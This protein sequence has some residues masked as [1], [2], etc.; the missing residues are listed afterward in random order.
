MKVY[1]VFEYP[2]IKDS[3]SPDAANEIDTLN[4]ALNI[5]HRHEGITG[6]IIRVTE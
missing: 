4:N 6:S 3:S 2:D 1:V 5:L